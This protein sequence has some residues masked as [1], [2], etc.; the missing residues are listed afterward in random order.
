MIIA[1]PGRQLTVKFDQIMFAISPC[2]CNESIVHQLSK[3]IVQEQKKIGLPEVVIK[4]EDLDILGEKHESG[5]RDN[6]FT[7]LFEDVETEKSNGNYIPDISGITAKGEIIEIEIVVTNDICDEKLDKIKT[8]GSSVI[9]INMR[10]YSSMQSFETLKNAVLY[11]APREWINNPEHELRYKD[12]KA[13]VEEDVNKRNNFIIEKVKEQQSL[14][15]KQE[16]K[17]LD[18][19]EDEV[20]LL[21]YKSA[22]GYS[23]KS[24]REFDFSVLHVGEIMKP[25]NSKNYSTRSISGLDINKEFYFDQSLIPQLEKLAFPCVVALSIGN[26]LKNGK[27]LP[28]VVEIDVRS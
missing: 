22:Y 11:D 19:K 15:T 9:S 28:L 21:G 12:V 16:V 27:L 7:L 18:P 24:S 6:R 5:L 20:I 23:P 13:K 1:R 17:L 3:Y 2:P 25:V 4:H 14:V 26:K 10:D 8:L